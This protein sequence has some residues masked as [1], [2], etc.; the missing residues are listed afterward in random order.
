MLHLSTNSPSKRF[1]FDKSFS[2]SILLIWSSI[3]PGSGVTRAG[4]SGLVGRR[5]V[6]AMSAS[7]A[8]GVDSWIWTCDLS[9]EIEDI[10]CFSSIN[11][12]GF[13]WI[14]T[15]LNSPL[16]DY[17]K[18]GHGSV[19]SVYTGWIK[20]PAIEIPLPELIGQSRPWLFPPHRTTPHKNLQ[21]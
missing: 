10:R 21:H 3:D 9:S 4:G 16:N 18:L 1:M 8:T 20:T 6:M 15:P 5:L 13:Q 12:W 11:H 17:T 2:R 7:A 14:P 19:V